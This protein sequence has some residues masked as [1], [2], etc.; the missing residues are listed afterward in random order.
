M[1]IAEI[2]RIRDKT[3]KAYEDALEAKSLGMN[4]RNLTRQD[5]DT[6]KTEFNDWDRRW[7]NARSKGKNKPYSLVNFTEY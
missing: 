1:N 5:L 7:R 2:K 3:L 6:L 4:G